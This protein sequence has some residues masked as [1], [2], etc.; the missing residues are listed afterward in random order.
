M[1]EA[2]PF[3]AIHVRHGSNSGQPLTRRDGVL[4]VTGAATYAADNHPDG[5]L[6]AVLA[7]SEHV[8]DELR[9]VGGRFAGVPLEVVPL[10]MSARAVTPVDRADA[11]GRLRAYAAALAGYEP[12]FV[13][14][15]VD[16]MTVSKG[17]WRDMRVLEHLDAQLKRQG[18]R[19]L[20]LLTPAGRCPQCGAFPS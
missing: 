14:T 11:A 12:D 20:Y 13:F 10:G 17:L 5:L 16:P 2:L 1:P 6:H 9:F 15:H 18:C 4:K 19:A 8:A 3:P 7:V